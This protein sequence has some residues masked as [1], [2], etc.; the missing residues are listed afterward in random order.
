MGFPPGNRLVF[1]PLAVVLG[2]GS[3]F[4][5][6]GHAAAPSRVGTVPGASRDGSPYPPSPVIRSVRWAPK[7]TIVRRARGSDNWPITW[8]DDDHL[9]TAYGDGR[10]FKPYVPRKL[11][12]GFAKVTGSPD[13]FMGVNI[14]SSSGEDL[15][16]G[17]RGKKGSGLLMVDGVLYLLARNAHN[18]QL[19]WSTDYARTWR[20]ADWRFATSF[21][22]PTFLNFGPNYAGARDSYVYI[23]SHD[24]DS[25]YEPADRMVLARVPKDR[26]RDRKAY[27]FFERIDTEGRPVWTK[28]IRRRGG[29]F[30]H[31]GHC[32]RSAVTY[33]A[34][35]GRY[36]WCQVHPPRAGDRGPRFEG[37]FGIYDAPEPWGPW[38]TVYFTRAWDVGP[39]E[40]NSLPTKWMSADGRTVYL[41]FS[42]DDCFSVRKATFE[43]S[44]TGPC[45]EA[46]PARR[47]SCRSKG[48]DRCPDGD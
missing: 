20:W 17:P 7:E 1:M 22:C 43:V 31:R 3:G 42:G 8:G 40:T 39:G 23:Y 9:Y 10:G 27:E 30:H 35:L 25:A 11:S 24:S 46:D 34:P 26:I 33:S 29:V 16:D 4:G 18:A 36:L 19:A 45:K 14:R 47:V 5:S 38:T 37:G 32:Y 21:G 13:H 44:G 28:D 12:L 6:A 15:G 41:V 2:I 48:T